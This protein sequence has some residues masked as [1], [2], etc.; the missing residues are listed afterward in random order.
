MSD[1]RCI[2]GSKEFFWTKKKI[3]FFFLTCENKYG[4][5]IPK[6][7]FFGYRNLFFYNTRT[8]MA[9]SDAYSRRVSIKMLKK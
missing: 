5:A 2:L 1:H 7:L 9:A 4:Y 3:L 8:Q 6:D